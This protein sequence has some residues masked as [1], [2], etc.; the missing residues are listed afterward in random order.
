[1]PLGWL[2]SLAAPPLCWSCGGGARPGGPLCAGCRRRL[3]WLGSG[4]VEVA[5]LPTWAPVAYDGP[6]R[7]LVGGLKFRRAAGLADAMA[8]QLAACAPPGL[9]DGVSLVPVPLEPGRLRRRGF[10]QAERLADALAR[11]AGVPSTACLERRRGERPQVGRSRA[12]RLAAARDTVTVAR[13]AEVPSRVLLVDDVITTGGTLAACAATLRAAGTR[14]VA[15]V[16]YA[17]TLGR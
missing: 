2:L 5:G 9:L 17:R 15:A 7:A 3:R 14:Q 11:R 4:L 13:A 16:A 10:N 12:E 8:A 6:A 1:M